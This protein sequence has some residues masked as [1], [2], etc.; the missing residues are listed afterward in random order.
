M[1]QRLARLV[2]TP[3]VIDL[4]AGCGGFGSGFADHGYRI[5]HAVE[6]FRPSLQTYVANVPVDTPL[7]QDVRKVDTAAMGHPDVVIGGPPCE[8]FTVA[9]ADR[10]KDPVDRLY[11]DPVGSL[12]IQYAILLKHLQPRVF[13]MENVAGILDG[14]LE[15]EL[16]TIFARAGYDKIHIHRFLAQ[17]FGTPSY[18]E[19]VFISNMPLAPKPTTRGQPITVRDAIGEIADLDA[20]ADIPNHQYTPVKG[21]RGK[22]LRETGTGKSIYHYKAADGRTHHV[23]TRLPW[24]QLAPTVKGLSRFIHPEDDRILTVREH[25]RLMGYPD[26]YV[27]HGSRNEAYN[28]TG[29]SVPPPLSAA[30]AKAMRVGLDHVEA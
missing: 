6:T 26:D 7:M 5:T 3:T 15:A 23:W 22:M 2:D 30:L 25:A 29:E 10:R 14:G 18:R 21:K 19:R 11:H 4:F 13:L 20:H 27:F 8:A 28:Q 17:D 12:T 24:D 1:T 16:H 9:N